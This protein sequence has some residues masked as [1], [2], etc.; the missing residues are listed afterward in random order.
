VDPSSE[1]WCFELR[2]PAALSDELSDAF[3][4]STLLPIAA[5]R[6]SYGFRED[7]DAESV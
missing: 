3:R 6:E 7:R 5:A 1:S 2:A 4:E